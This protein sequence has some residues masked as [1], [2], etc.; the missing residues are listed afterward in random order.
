MSASGSHSIPPEFAELFVN[1]V[2]G[3]P[4]KNICGQAIKEVATIDV[5]RNVE[6]IKNYRNWSTSAS[7][8]PKN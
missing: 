4:G 3:A 8:R 5:K 1:L 2:V 6:V 7:I